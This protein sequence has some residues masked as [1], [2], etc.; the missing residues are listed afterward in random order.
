MIVVAALFLHIHVWE[1]TAHCDTKNIIIVITAMMRLIICIDL[2][3]WN[4]AKP[5]CWGDWRLWNEVS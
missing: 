4:Y 3:E 5:V 2:T 1:I